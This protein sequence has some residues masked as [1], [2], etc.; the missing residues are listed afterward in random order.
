[1]HHVQHGNN[2]SVDI[3]R[4]AGHAR[5]L[6]AHDQVGQRGSNVHPIPPK[7]YRL[8]SKARLIDRLLLTS[9]PLTTTSVQYID[10]LIGSTLVSDQQALPNARSIHTKCMW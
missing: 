9:S 1:M 5:A 3:L 8:R 10:E 6:Q 7:K 2:M 4:D